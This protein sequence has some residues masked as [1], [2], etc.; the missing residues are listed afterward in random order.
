MAQTLDSSHLNLKDDG[1]QPNIHEYQRYIPT[2]AHKALTDWMSMDVQSNFTCLVHEWS[3]NLLEKVLL[4]II[5]NYVTHDFPPSSVRCLVPEILAS[6][7]SHLP[8]SQTTCFSYLRFMDGKLITLT[9]FNHSLIYC[10]EW[11]QA[12]P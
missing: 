6:P 3:N 1:C 8:L 2:T 4:I 11:L 7:Y 5:F 12:F 10:L 9:I